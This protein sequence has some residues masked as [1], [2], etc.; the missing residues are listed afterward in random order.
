MLIFAAW[1]EFAKMD[2]HEGLKKVAEAFQLPK[3]GERDKQPDRFILYGLITEALMQQLVDVK[4]SQVSPACQLCDIKPDA[5]ITL[6]AVKDNETISSRCSRMIPCGSQRMLVFNE[7]SVLIEGEP[8]R[9][10]RDVWPTD[11][12]DAEWQAMKD[13]RDGMPSLVTLAMQKEIGGAMRRARDIQ[14]TSAVA[15]AAQDWIVFALQSSAHAGE[16]EV[17]YTTV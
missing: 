16:G 13:T 11:G 3:R 14:V 7:F 15:R 5:E 10:A 6:A 8:T 17:L 12:L 9:Q 2:G 1:F 4:P